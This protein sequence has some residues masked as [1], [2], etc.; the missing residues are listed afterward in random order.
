MFA[1]IKVVNGSFSVHAEGMTS[2]ASAK[3]SYH[4]LCQALWNAPDVITGTVAIVDETL[5]PLMGYC[6]SIEHPKTEATE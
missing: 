2:L 3:T 1:I 5:R 4:G 6:E